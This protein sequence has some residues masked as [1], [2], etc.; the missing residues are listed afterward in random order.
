MFSNVQKG[1]EYGLL[2]SLK[3]L[4]FWLVGTCTSYV[5]L[6]LNRVSQIVYQMGREKSGRP[7][8]VGHVNITKWDHLRI[9]SW[10]KPEHN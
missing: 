8:T 4:P 9:L 5:R 6:S 1:I 7:V 2:E 10:S 3:M